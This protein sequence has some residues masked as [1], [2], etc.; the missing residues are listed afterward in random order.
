MDM[1]TFLPFLFLLVLFTGCGSDSE[2]TSEEENGN[3]T[4]T[5]QAM[6]GPVV[7]AEVS[8]Y[9]ATD[10]ES[11][12]LCRTQTKDS[13][14]ID[15]AGKIELPA[16]CVDE[17]GIYLLLISGGLDIDA[18]DDGQIDQTATEVQGRFHTLL[19]G[20]QLLSGRA[21]AT[22]LTEA[23]YQN[24]RYLLAA[25][26]NKDQ[27]IQSLDIS[28][29]NLLNQDLN[30][31][32]I[33][34]HLDLAQWHPRLNRETTKPSIDQLKLVIQAIHEDH[35]TAQHT[36]QLF[37]AITPP[38][39][40]DFTEIG[41]P[42]RVLISDH[43]LYAADMGGITVVDVS[44]PDNLH[45]IAYTENITASI[46]DMVTVGE[47]LYVQSG[48]SSTENH[49]V[50]VYDISNRENPQL[51]VTDLYHPEG[52]ELNHF[53]ASGDYGF[54][55]V[56]RVNNPND[57]ENISH[58]FRLDI[59]DLSTLDQP[60]VLAS[61]EIDSYG[62]AMAAVD[63]RLYLGTGVG[64]YLQPGGLSIIDIT[65]PGSPSKLSELELNNVIE[66]K[67]IGEVGYAITES[68][69]SGEAIDQI[70]LLDLRNDSEILVSGSID[71][72]YESWTDKHLEI[73]DGVGYIATPNGV[74]MYD[75]S[76]PANPAQLG[77]VIT[78]GATNSLA[79][80]GSWLFAAVQNL[81]LQV[82]NNSGETAVESPAIVD[83]IDLPDVQ[84]MIVDQSGIAYLLTGVNQSR[85]IATVDLTDP[86]ERVVAST[87]VF[88]QP[89]RNPILIDQHLYTT[90]LFAGV[91][92]FDIT[93]P[94]QPSL[95]SIY[96]QSV[97]QFA[98]AIAVSGERAVVGSFGFDAP[99]GDE[100]GA[101]VFSLTVLNVAE[102]AD[103]LLLSQLIVD[104]QANHIAIRDDI[105][106][107]ISSDLTLNTYRITADGEL[108]E[109][110]SMDFLSGSGG[111]K[112]LLRGDY[113]FVSQTNNAVSVLDITNPA[114]PSVLLLIDTQ[115]PIGDIHIDGN[116][117]LI[118]GQAGNLQALNIEN[119]EAPT[120]V[121]NY[122]TPSP[123]QAVTVIN[124]QV[125]VAVKD[126]VV[127]SDL[128]IHPV[129]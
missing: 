98:S 73:V 41:V 39:V 112:I 90:S 57:Y 109:L 16:D 71:T 33:I 59:L 108:D 78:N 89:Y 23:A 102:S 70:T 67:V 38:S 105:V 82:F 110:A 47:R 65:D 77:R 96:D 101:A 75:L 116:L 94:M 18:D 25:G 95:D 45:T 129:P 19:S 84:E 121:G 28:A 3:Q 2:N 9:N 81:G 114:N 72:D 30:G 6:L 15:L 4:F 66:L 120:I 88:P 74:E 43:L 53:Y 119:P 5:S 126:Q 93:H 13:E 51:L 117:L 29:R 128:P 58:E 64:P 36:I 24:V 55:A 62:S 31:D 54:A 91:T 35:S 8:I 104:Y 11:G 48:S 87:E 106:Y 124:D 83:R 50:A 26:A 1:K 34:N 42:D 79:I 80:S 111:A 127:I 12:L 99:N 56:H 63:D 49:S 69:V 115:G 113:A 7:G 52:F 86:Q 68:E 27:L 125:Y 37:D 118:A 100:I 22:V 40:S 10:L 21:M 60:I 123:A 76:N 92:L 85:A 61:L 46:S 103:P 20:S 107:V 122:H 32:L 17:D 97:I 44:D 14:A